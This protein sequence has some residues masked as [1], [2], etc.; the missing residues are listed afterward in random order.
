MNRRCCT[1]EIEDL[2][3]F[4]VH[5]L[6]D[7]VPDQLERLVIEQMPDVA[8]AACEEVVEADDVHP[9]VEQAIA[10]MRSKKSGATRDEYL[11]GWS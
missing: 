3:D 5:R 4:E 6:G 8:A 7:I 9:V 2:I 11:A 10:Q 1:G